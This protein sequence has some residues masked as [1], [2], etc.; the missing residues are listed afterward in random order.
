MGGQANSR[1][2]NGCSCLTGVSRRHRNNMV[3][4]FSTS[5]LRTQHFAK[6][7]NFLTVATNAL[8]SRSGQRLA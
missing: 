7:M 6:T 2:K 1:P 4:A 3:Q 5:G 8:R